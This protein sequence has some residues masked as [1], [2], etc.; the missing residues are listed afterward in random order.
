VVF[1]VD[2]DNFYYF[3]ISQTGRYR[4]VRQYRGRWT[5]VIDWTLSDAIRRDEVNRI[6]VVGQGERFA[7]YVN[8]TLVA[9]VEDDQIGSGRV[10]VSMQLHHADDQAAFAFDDFVVRTP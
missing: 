10:G 5:N 4:F 2:G 7:C 8:N 3:G 9:T 1:R 6:T